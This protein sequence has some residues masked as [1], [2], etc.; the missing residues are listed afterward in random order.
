M[1]IRSHTCHHTELTASDVLLRLRHFQQAPIIAIWS[2]LGG[3]VPMWQKEHPWRCQCGE[4]N[5]QGVTMWQKGTPMLVSMWQKQHRWWFERG[6]RN[7]HVV[8]IWRKE[9]PWC[10]NVAKGT[11]MVVWT[12][13]KEHPW[14]YLWQ[15]EHPRWCQCGERNT[16]GGVNV[17]KGTPMG[18]QCGK[19]NT[20]GVSMWQKE[21]PRWCQRQKKHPR[22]CQCV[23]RNTHGGVNVGKGTPTAVSMWRKEHPCCALSKAQIQ[24]L[25]SVPL[26]AH[27]AVK[28]I[29]ERTRTASRNYTIW[30]PEVETQRTTTGRRILPKSVPFYVLLKDRLWSKHAKYRLE[31]SQC[32]LGPRVVVADILQFHLRFGRFTRAHKPA[33]RTSSVRPVYTSVS[34]RTTKSYHPN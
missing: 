29:A 5:T 3:E 20:H 9:Q 21:H 17:A 28:A 1:S 10:V 31:I 23:E 13:Q 8:S 30:G 7:T 27:S 6:K 18:C 33:A 22:W 14:W 4:R 34:L 24:Q 16:H 12:W 19:R 15:K 26:P 11:T 32:I 2:L 25:T